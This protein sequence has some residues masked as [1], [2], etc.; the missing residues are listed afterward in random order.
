MNASDGVRR[1]GERNPAEDEVR[2]R[3]AA[4]ARSYMAALD[5]AEA[6][7]DVLRRALLY[8]RDRN[9]SDNRLSQILTEFIPPGT[10]RLG[11]PVP[12]ALMGVRRLTRR[13]NPR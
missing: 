5:D 13:A 1:R 2:K 9:F 11:R 8:G 12:R 4:A 3:V 6:A 7:Q 10:V